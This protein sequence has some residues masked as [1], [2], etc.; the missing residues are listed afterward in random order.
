MQVDDAELRLSPSYFRKMLLKKEG[1]IIG[2]FD[3]RVVAE[4]GDRIDPHPEFDPS[5]TFIV[6][7]F[8]AAANAYT[9]G[10][11]GY[12]NDQPYRILASLP[13]SYAKFANRYASMEPRLGDAM[14][15]NPHLRLLVCQGLRDMAV[16]PD[17]MA[18]S[19]NHLPIPV[20]LRKNIT[21]ATYDSGHM[22]YLL[23]KDAAKLR[24]DIVGW[25]K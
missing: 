16:P 12:E 7:P 6:G 4:D 21:I 14:K 5:F 22:M 10:V 20:S 8:S 2:R 24:E 25:L 1:K 17:A 23:D 19:L 9:R 18:Y 13:W 3:S 15:S 11:L